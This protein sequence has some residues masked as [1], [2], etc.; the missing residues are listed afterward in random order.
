MQLSAK[1]R[2]SLSLLF[3]GIIA[4]AYTGK[5]LH[6]H[7][8]EYYADFERTEC[9]ASG[10]Q[11]ITDDCHICHFSFYTYL[12]AVTPIFVFAT[13]LRIRYM[14]VT[15]PKCIE[16]PHLYRS[17]RAPPKKSSAIL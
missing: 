14:G 4:T 9:T 15:M 12:Y 13:L 11:S 5:S 17:L 16:E 6:H 10:R 7:S 3:L 1:H 2:F 8:D